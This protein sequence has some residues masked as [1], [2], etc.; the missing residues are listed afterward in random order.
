M[1]D[2]TKYRSNDRIEFHNY[3]K[4]KPY[5]QGSHDTINIVGYL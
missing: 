1:T 4:T 3:D 2:N 5:I